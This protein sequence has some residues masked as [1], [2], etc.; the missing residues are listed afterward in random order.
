MTLVRRLARPL[1]AASFIAAG[2]DAVLHPMP[3]AETMRPLVDRFAP[4]V[5]LP[6]DAELAVRATGALQIAAGALFALGRLPRVSAVLL[7]ASVLPSAAGGTPFWREKDPQVRAEQRTE[8]LR[9]AGLLGGALLGAVDTEGRPGLAWRGRR[10]VAQAEKAGR[11][12]AR[13]AK[14]SAKHARA[15]AKVEVRQRKLDARQ[16]L[17]GATAVLPR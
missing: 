11:R 14:R 1:L 5:G 17:A 10:A 16:V 4:A 2:V 8:L 12:A 7:A 6:A 3:A 13:D 9:T 15:A